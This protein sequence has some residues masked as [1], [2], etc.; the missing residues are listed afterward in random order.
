MIKKNKFE[1]EENLRKMIQ[2]IMSNAQNENR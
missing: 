2:N 1:I